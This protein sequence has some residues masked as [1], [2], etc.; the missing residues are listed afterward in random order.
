[1]ITLK[2]LPPF[3]PRDL[4]RDAVVPVGDASRPVSYGMF[5]ED[6]MDP[7]LPVA[8]TRRSQ[9]VRAGSETSSA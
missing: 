1:M 3:V 6:V 2:S 5:P 8:K 7:D 4:E 9:W